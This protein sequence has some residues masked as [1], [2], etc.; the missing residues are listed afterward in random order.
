M[1]YVNPEQRQ[2]DDALDAALKAQTNKAMDGPKSE[3]PLKRQWDDELE[4]ELEA[5]LAGFDAESLAV[6]SPR[7]RAED[8]KHVPKSAVGQ[9][10]A[11]GLRKGK[12]IA[13]RG[14][15]VFVDLGAKS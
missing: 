2:V 12:V 15:I 13:I 5:A 8:R 9:E 7:T 1:A 3:G 10:A 11:P 4:A 14:K 6:D